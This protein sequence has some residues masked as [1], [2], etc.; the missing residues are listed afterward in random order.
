MNIIIYNGPVDEFT[1]IVPETNYVSLTTFIAFIDNRTEKK[2]AIISTLEDARS[3][4]VYSSEYASAMEHFIENFANYLAIIRMSSNIDT[5][6]LH[7]P[8]SS[9]RKQLKRHQFEIYEESYDYLK[10][11]RSDIRTIRDKFNEVVFGQVEARNKILETI[12]PLTNKNYDKPIVIMLY[13]PSGVGKTETAKLINSVMYRDKRIFRKQLSMFQ[14][15]E[16][17]NYLFGDR[18]NSF[19]KDLLDRETN[20][21]LLDEFDKAHPMFFSAFYEVFE[22]GSFSD[23]YYEVDLKNTI[24]ICTSNYTSEEE[25]EL[26][27]GAAISSRFDAHI[28]YDALSDEAKMKIADIAYRNHIEK[29]DASDRQVIEENNILN[30]F[31]LVKDHF[32]NARNINKIIGN[33]MA[34]SIIRQL[35]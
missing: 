5:V 9:I 28:C 31:Y 4:V 6:F 27:L 3:L 11:S 25:I 23:K 2:E 22:E 34:Q 30:K 24:I 33:S 13:G 12:F 1:E 18:S 17:S 16:Y 8:P 35:E 14:N 29:Y 7:N 20:V 26:M 15:N 21:I 10:I 19:A 32:D